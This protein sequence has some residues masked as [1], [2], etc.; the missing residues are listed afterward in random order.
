MGHPEDLSGSPPSIGARIRHYRN[1]LNLSQHD[2]AAAL[3]FKSAQIVSQIENDE[4]E[5]KA[6]ELVL[7]AK[8]LST[9][10]DNL[11]SASELHLP[12]ARWRDRP[13]EGFEATEAKLCLRCERYALLE[14][15][16]DEGARRE[17]PQ[18]SLPRGR[19]STPSDV[20]LAANEIRAAMQLGGRPAASLQGVLEEWYGI[21][22]FYDSFAGS[23]LCV[24]GEFGKAILLNRNQVRWRRNFSLAHEVFHLVAANCYGDPDR[25]TEEKHANI[26]ASALLL[27]SDSLLP[28]LDAKA[29]NG[30]VALQDLILTAREFD[31]S[32]EALL[33]RLCNLRKLTAENVKDLTSNRAVLAFEKWKLDLPPALP[34]RFERLT[35]SAYQRG[36]I[37][38]R[39]LAEFLEIS[40]NQLAENPEISDPDLSLDEETEIAFA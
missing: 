39:K 28:P 13:S 3:N 4:R 30:K 29:R 32:T 36:R 25:E 22:I 27:P 31:V 2:L 37:G 16:N 35:Y 15:W 14:E 5:I 38:K 6:R 34:E 40:V 23:G 21:R 9:S 8:A 10:V 26:F 12:S 18:G 17:L 33:W 20:E 19:H 1:R 7:L 24:D 11:L